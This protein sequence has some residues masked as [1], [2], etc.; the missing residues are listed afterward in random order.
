MTSSQHDPTLQSVATFRIINLS[1]AKIVLS[2]T[3]LTVL[4]NLCVPN[5]SFKSPMT[6]VMITIAITVTL[7]TVKEQLPFTTKRCY[8]KLCLITRQLDLFAEF[9][10]NDIWI[11][12]IILLLSGW[13]LNIWENGISFVWWCFIVW[14][15]NLKDG[16]S[17]ETETNKT[18]NI[19]VAE[20]GFKYTDDS[21][22]QIETDL[23]KNQYTPVSHYPSLIDDGTSH[24]AHINSLEK[25]LLD[26]ET[27]LTAMENEKVQQNIMIYSFNH[28]LSDKLNTFDKHIQEKD[29]RFQAKI[30]QIQAGL[31]DLENAHCRHLHLHILVNFCIVYIKERLVGILPSWITTLL[32]GLKRLIKLFWGEIRAT[33]FPP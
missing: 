29:Q 21:R 25:K 33:L 27:R 3:V 2:G 28:S 30:S 13:I 8:Y 17:N 32:K 10:K 12:V 23:K 11:S 6:I 19:P 26:L 15:Y 4:E 7:Y 5:V 20:M 1:T 31:K 14:I 22:V 24:I 9:M 16:V 18:D